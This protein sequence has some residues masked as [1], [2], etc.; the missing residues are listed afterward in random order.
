MLLQVLRRSFENPEKWSSP[1][2]HTAG[3]VFFGT[4][5]RG[6]SGLS[7]AEIVDAVA[8]GT[9]EKVNTDFR[10]YSDTMALS[11]KEN[12][13]LQDIVERYTMTRV[14][15]HPIPLWCFYELLPSPV[16]KTLQNTNVQ[17]VSHKHRA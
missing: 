1:F 7:L 9:S 8:Q 4:P 12:P 2:Q 5:F 13:Y 16:G 3:L 6:R 14:G 17:D 10:K 15:D 11:V